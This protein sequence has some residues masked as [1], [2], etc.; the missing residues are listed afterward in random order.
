MS[1]KCWVFSLD[2]LGDTDA[3]LFE[4]LPGFRRMMAEGCYRPHMRSVYPTLTYPAHASIISGRPPASTG[5]VNNLHVQPRREVQDWYWF[6]REIQGDTLFRAARRENKS[7][8]ALLWPVSAGAKIAYNLSEIIPNRW[9]HHQVARVL[10]NSTAS[11][12]LR[13]EK[14]YGSLR[15]G[16]QEPFLD[17][18][19]EACAFDL[20]DRQDPDLLFVHWVDVDAQKHDH[21][22]RSNE[23]QDA[24]RRI[25]ARIQRVLDKRASRADRDEIDIVLLSDHSQIDTPHFLYPLDEL[26]RDGWLTRSGNIVPQYR[27][28]PHSAGGSCYFYAAE[29]LSEEEKIRFMTYLERWSEREEI[30]TVYSRE[31]A[32]SLGADPTCLAMAEAASGYM[33][34]SFF[35][36]TEQAGK[37]QKGHAAN[38]G[39][40]PDKPNYNAIFIAA[41]PSFKRGVRNE[42]RGSILDIAPTLARA[43]RLPLEGAVG[44]AMENFLN[45]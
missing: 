5:I 12:V 9:W 2:A 4:T 41:G 34:S 37:E 21:G 13:W 29:H 42:E 14:K 43:H 8:G 39:F 17:D 3:P 18:F 16:I 38:H 24:I 15:R 30:E 11:L 44:S 23:V 7:V 40:S 25:D 20:I 33:F 36:E 19:T 27:V 31:Q 6:E 26:A 10:C 35:A 1:K 45:G 28:F 32:R 22:I